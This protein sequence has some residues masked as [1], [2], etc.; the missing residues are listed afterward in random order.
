MAKSGQDDLIGSFLRHLL[1]PETEQAYRLLASL[2]YPI[3]DGRTFTERLKQAGGDAETS[4]LLAGLFEPEDFGM[5]TV[6]SAFEKFYKRSRHLILPGIPLPRASLQLL[7]DIV[8]AGGLVIQDTE[9]VF[10]SRGAVT[11]EC[12]CTDSTGSGQGGTCE[13]IVQGNILVCSGGTCKGSCT[14]T[15]RIPSVNLLNLATATF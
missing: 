15:T 10:R 4:R 1:P 7:A 2:E 3:P 6:Q 13:I 5:D 11:V 14:L 9:V 12:S 8:N